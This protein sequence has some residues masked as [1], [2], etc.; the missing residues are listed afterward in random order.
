MTD[1]T[2]I[3]ATIELDP[4]AFDPEAKQI[5]EDM[6]ALDEAIAIGK[7]TALEVSIRKAKAL[8]EAETITIDGQTITIEEAIEE[9]IALEAIA[10]DTK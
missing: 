6:R 2:L 1:N 10:Q 5:E 8:D 9:A 3:D 4:E 7:A